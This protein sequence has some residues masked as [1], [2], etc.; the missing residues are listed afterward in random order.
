M[1]K[2]LETGTDRG[3]ERVDR[4]DRR[5]RIKN[6]PMGSWRSFRPLATLLAVIFAT[7]LPA[8]LW[9]VPGDVDTG[10]DPKANNS[11][12]SAVTQ[13]DGKIV[14]GGNFTTLQPNGA[15]SA[16]VRNGVARLNADGSLD[17]NFNPNANG[18]LVSV[19]VQTDG[20][21][22]IG[23]GFTAL[24]PNGAASAVTRNRIARLNADGSLDA[25]FNPNANDIVQSI[26]LQA[27]GKIIIGGYFTALQPNGAPIP[28]ARNYIA[29][30]NADGSLD[31]GFD[32]N[33]N[34]KIYSAAVQTDGKI[35]IAGYFTALRVNGAATAVVRNHIARFHADGALDTKFDPNVNGGVY[36][37]ALQADG[38]IL[39]GG[40]FTTVQPNG[41]AASALRNN[42][43][44][45]HAD[46]ALDANFNPNV[47]GLVI[48]VA[49]QTDGKI[50]MGGLFTAIQPANAGTFTTRNRLA[51]LNADGALDAGFN[52]NANAQA[53]NVTGQ[54]DGKIIIGG[55]LTALQPNGANNAIARNR[56]ARLANDAA[57]QS[58]TVPSASRVQWLRGTA[59]P[60]TQM[61]SF[62]LSM[63]GGVSWSS[64]G[65]GVRIAGGWE[66]TGLSLPGAGHIRAR[67]RLISGYG[68]GSGGLAETSTAFTFADIVVEQPAG[69]ALNS[70]KDAVDFGERLL[71]AGSSSKTFT[72]RNPGT[73]NLTL[74]AIVADGANAG[75]FLVNAAGASAVVA[76]GGSTT[77]RVT[78]AP[79]GTVSGSRNATLHIAS[80]VG[81]DKNPFD[82]A[83]T[84]LGLSTAA[85]SDGD[86]L[87]DHAEYQLAALGFDWQTSQA[88]LVNAYYANANAAGLYTAAQMQALKVDAPLISRLPQSGLFKL[89]ISVKQSANLQSFSPLPLTAGQTS[90]NAQGELEFLFNAPADAAFFRLEAR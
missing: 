84:G 29:R 75:D 17:A 49:A 42:M 73:S 85:D 47:N 22:L 44:R 76:P 51:R 89:T 8:A 79:S 2:A 77:F 64:L 90:L 18:G 40:G 55:D 63:D 13:A 23:G 15:A 14:I 78:F 48:S 19:V 1:K 60:E 68:N 31:T 37:V 43:A 52:P 11:V 66:R 12:Y 36:S 7:V 59:S 16:V 20:K 21:I 71:G 82:I 69:V 58:L 83:L 53:V 86:G 4:T 80:N 67:A 27:D 56:I 87:N 5:N 28:T 24:Q 62:E 70:G 3:M 39:L 6:P 35:I 46:G 30:L 72:V 32:P 50:L 34:E 57:T 33:A 41:A 88:T 10:F 54:A 61:V 9:A 45:L 25:S 81:G 38:K 26:V 65:A 74:G